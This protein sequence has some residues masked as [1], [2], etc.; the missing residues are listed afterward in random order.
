MT[1]SQIAWKTSLI[2]L[3][4]V[5]VPQLPAIVSYLSGV[6]PE[7]A[8]TLSFLGAVATAL[9][10]FLRELKVGWYIYVFGE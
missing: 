1:R 9:D 6:K 4:R 2:R 5:L 3:V 10:K 7:W 8:A